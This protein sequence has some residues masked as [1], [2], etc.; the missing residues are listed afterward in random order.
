MSVPLLRRLFTVKEY[1]K[2]VE[3]GVFF[4]DGQIELS[5]WS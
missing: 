4:P 2:M 5:R 1:H 3:A